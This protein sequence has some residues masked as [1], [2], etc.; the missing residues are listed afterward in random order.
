M[1]SQPINSQPV[2][3]GNTVYIGSSDGTLYALNSDSG[4]E[5]WRLD[6]QSAIITDLILEDGIL[7]FANQGNGADIPPTF[8]SVDT[9]SQG[10]DALTYPVPD[11]DTIL[12]AEGAA[13]GVVYFYGRQIVYAVNM[14]NIVHEFQVDTQGNPRIFQGVKVWASD[15]LAITNMLNAQGQPTQIG[16]TSPL[17]LETDTAGK[18]ALALSTF[19]A[20]GTPLVNCP[21]LLA[22]ANFMMP[23]ETI[24]IYPD[25]EN[26]TTLSTVRGNPQDTSVGAGV[27]ATSTMDLASATGYDGTPLLSS[28]YLT[29]SGAAAAQVQIAQTIRNTVGMAPPPSLNAVRGS[30]AAKYLAYPETMPNVRY[31]ASTNTPI[32]RAYAAGAVPY[33]TTVRAADGTITFQ[34]L[35]SDA[36]AQA[37]I[38]QLEA[39]S[40]G[41]GVG[42]IFTDI[43]DFV[44]HVVKSSVTLLQHVWTVVDNIATLA[45]QTLENGV[46]NLY[47]LTITT[48]EDALTAVVGFFNQVVDDLKKVIQ[49]LSFSFNWGDIQCVHKEIEAKLEANIQTGIAWLSA[50]KSDVVT[51][52]TT[53]LVAD[54]DA[55]FDKFTQSPQSTG[56]PQSAQA[57]NGNPN[58]VYNQNGKNYSGSC[59]FVQRRDLPLPP[60]PRSR[61]G[62]RGRPRA[63]R[64][65]LA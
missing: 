15:A 56:S 46:K 53:T 7:Y 25:H 35:A 3:I 19:D 13:N 49:F 28:A 52:L 2:V 14:D 33:W 54:V 1:S 47:K 10:Y 11:A 27:S 44:Q 38:A 63:T 12:F 23:G 57:Q 42:S 17:W 36:D 37:L 26:A 58:Q 50:H 55:V 32:T 18:V 20:D 40:G 39:E 48:L 4:D 43:K 62:N 41:T 9:I 64:P 8:Y 30:A 65:T 29:G 5:L 24:V 31:S 45:F 22:W 60:S 51:F 6:T 61:C 16:P 34:A 21:T 59:N